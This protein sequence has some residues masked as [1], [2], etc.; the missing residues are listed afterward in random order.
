MWWHYQIQCK[1]LKRAIYQANVYNDSLRML[2]AFSNVIF[3]VSGEGELQEFIT[4]SKI[5]VSSKTLK[6]KIF[7]EKQKYKRKMS[8]TEQ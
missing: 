4:S 6:T 5:E 1:L 7:N 8:K 2:G 3:Y